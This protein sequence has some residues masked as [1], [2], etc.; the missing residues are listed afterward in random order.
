VT[1]TKECPCAAAEKAVFPCG[2]DHCRH[3]NKTGRCANCGFTGRNV[4]STRRP[5]AGTRYRVVEN[6]RLMRPPY[7]VRE[8]RGGNIACFCFQREQAELSAAALQAPRSAA[9]GVAAKGGD[10][11]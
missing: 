3:F 9:A 6:D 1:V 2:A 7:A 5:Q 8:G 10:R 11:G 4:A